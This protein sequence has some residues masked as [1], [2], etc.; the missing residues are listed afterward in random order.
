MTD[1]KNFSAILSLIQCDLD[2]FRSEMMQRFNQLD[3]GFDDFG[4]EL[5]A[6]PKRTGK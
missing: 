2:K 5:D 1:F 6:L 4:K 3:A